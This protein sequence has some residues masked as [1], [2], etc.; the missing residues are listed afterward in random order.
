MNA[1]VWLFIYSFCP[2]TILYSS[3]I[4]HVCVTGGFHNIVASG[5]VVSGKNIGY[6]T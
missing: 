2:R 3:K 5:F 1:G 6:S 4:L